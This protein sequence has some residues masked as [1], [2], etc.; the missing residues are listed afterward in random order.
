MERKTSKVCSH[1][2]TEKPTTEFYRGSVDGWRSRCKPCHIAA[3]ADT[4]ARRKARDPEAFR[5]RRAQ[6]ERLSYRRANRTQT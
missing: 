4:T 1:C 2:Q 5:T 3:V 6:I